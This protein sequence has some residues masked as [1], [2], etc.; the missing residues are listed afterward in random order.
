MRK[1]V[2]LYDIRSLSVSLSL[3]VF[4]NFWLLEVLIIFVHV[5]FSIIIFLCLL[6]LFCKTI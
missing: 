6:F 3:S 5:L 4:L 1:L 2:L